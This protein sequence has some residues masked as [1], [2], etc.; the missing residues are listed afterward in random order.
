[1]ETTIKSI[2]EEMNRQD[3]RATQFP[4]YVVQETKEVIT[5]EDFADYYICVDE[6]GQKMDE[7]S[8][9]EDCEGEDELRSPCVGCGFSRRVPV[10]EEE[11]FA[12][13]AGVFLTAKACEEHIESNKY[14]YS[15][16]RSY[17]ISA[18]RNYEMQ[19]IMQFLSSQAG[20]VAPFYR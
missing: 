2:G 10:K 16:P 19:A 18:W 15:K 20:Q 17:A 12:L 7:E 13:R 14:H 11:V 1:M 9:C 4:L 8:L 3:N 6:E 5:H